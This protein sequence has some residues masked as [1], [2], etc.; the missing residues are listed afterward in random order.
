MKLLIKN[1][2]IISDELS[3]NRLADVLIEDKVIKAVGY[4]L[5]A[6]DAEVINADG[7]YVFPGFVDMH[8]NI[9]D[10]GHESV[11][12]IETASI[13]AANGGFTTI[14]AQPDTMPAVDNKT[15]VEYII[16]KSRQYS[17]VNIYPYGSMTLGCLGEQIS[18]IGEM[19]HAGIV[20]IADGD[21]TVSNADLMRNIFIYSKMFDM[22]VITHCEDRAL[23][24][25]G[26]MNEGC[27]STLLGLL[28]MP[29][30]AEDI[31]VSRNI[32]L[33]ESVGARLHIAHV[34]TEGSVRIIRE[35][36][37]RGVQVTCDTCPHYFTLTEDAAMQY[38]TFAKVIPP[39]RTKSDIEEII[40][41][42]AD[43]TIDVI[44]SGH[45]PV[46][47]ERKQSEF[48]TA[49]YGI[50][51]FETAFALC[52]TKLVKTGI[53]SPEE[54]AVKLSLNPSNIL[55]FKGKGK[56]KS[57][58]YADITIAECEKE[59]KIDASKFLSKAKFTPVNG[60]SVTGRILQTIV[61]G[62]T[63]FD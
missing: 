56:I 29:R 62:K 28:G 44:S 9:C 52:W 19:A 61:G 22:P 63:V 39:F 38:N 46:R 15:V 25:K 18:E 37:K 21:L 27:V 41:G 33:A 42:I 45:S 11:E 60:I 43:G 31:I 57:G 17:K 13:S 6:D 59:Y 30:E 40:K 5:T 7:A 32:I 50:S 2:K 58:Y 34:S 20:G 55:G 10:P 48:D 47:I 3:E 53:I 12:D 8:C 26:V 1:G 49:A 14:T 23:S 24:G 51:A 4:D 16:T 35:A 36:K 54:L